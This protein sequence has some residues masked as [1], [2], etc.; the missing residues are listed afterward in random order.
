M[1][2]LRELGVVELRHLQMP[3]SLE[4]GVDEVRSDVAS[5]GALQIRPV[6]QVEGADRCRDDPTGVEAPDVGKQLDE[7]VR[8]FAAPGGVKGIDEHDPGPI[9]RPAGEHFRQRPV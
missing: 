9:P 6:A 4:L 7:R 2:Q 5:E 3:N 1:L 8:A